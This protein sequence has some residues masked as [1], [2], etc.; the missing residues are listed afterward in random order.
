MK[1]VVTLTIA[2]LLSACFAI[3]DA[4]GQGGPT[5]GT[6]AC[7]PNETLQGD[8]YCYFEGGFP[9]YARSHRLN[10]CTRGA[11]L[12][13]R[14]GLCVPVGGC[15]GGGI[16]EERPACGP[17]ETYRDGG[18]YTYCAPLAPCDHTRAECEAGWTLDTVR[19][20]CSGNCRKHSRICD[21]HI[22]GL[23]AYANPCTWNI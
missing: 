11:P 3:T 22:S 18:C 14:W 4:Q 15:G 5:C 21:R 6:P 17:G 19:G 8:G 20:V 12:D 10:D 1:S 2:T 13:S 7:Q 16:C 9:S 23:V